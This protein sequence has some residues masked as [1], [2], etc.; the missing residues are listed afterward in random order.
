MTEVEGRILRALERQTE[1]LERIATALEN[2]PAVD[3]AKVIENVKA[4]RAKTNELAPTGGIPVWESYAEAYRQRYKVEPVRNAKT[5]SQCV[6]IAKRLGENGPKVA[7]F[8]V[9]HNDRLYL[10]S[11]HV[12]DLLVRDAEKIHTDWERGG[13]PTSIDSVNTEKMAFAKGQLER[14]SKGEL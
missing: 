7:A 12:L 10:N 3:A 14:I 11:R 13:A 6:Q 8:F 2:R 4:R 9:G 1:L 5:N